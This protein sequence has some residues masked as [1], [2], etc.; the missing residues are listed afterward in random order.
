MSHSDIGLLFGFIMFCLGMGFGFFIG[1]LH[2]YDKV[3][4]RY[5]LYDNEIRNKIL[6]IVDK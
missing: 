6:D 5:R 2:G 4:K 1:A 3:I